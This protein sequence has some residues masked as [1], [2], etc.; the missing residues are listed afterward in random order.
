MPGPP[1]DQAKL[2]DPARAEGQDDDRPQDHREQQRHRERQLPLEHQEVHLHVLEVLQD[3][4]EDDHQDHYA[5][6]QRSPRATEAGLAL[7]PIGLLALYF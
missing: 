4:D 7:A 3:E 2:K 5:D 1:C 6:D